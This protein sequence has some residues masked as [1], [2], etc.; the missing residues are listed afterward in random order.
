MLYNFFVGGRKISGEKYHYQGGNMRCRSDGGGICFWSDIQ[1]YSRHEGVGLQRYADE[2]SRAGVSTVHHFVGG[3]RHSLFALGGWDQQKFC[4]KKR[5]D[6]FVTSLFCVLAENQ[7]S[8]VWFSS[9]ETMISRLPF[10][11]RSLSINSFSF[12][13]SLRV[14]SYVSLNML[15]ILVLLTFTR[16]QSLVYSLNVIRLAREAISV[17][18][19]PIFTPNKSSR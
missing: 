2:Y 14:K 9:L 5:C 19:P 12:L 18:T 8:P 4:I 6:T 7:S 15:P 16:S 13:E 11:S 17:P 1:H 10:L 3:D